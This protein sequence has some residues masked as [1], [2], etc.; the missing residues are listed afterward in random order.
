MTSTSEQEIR[1]AVEVLLRHKLI[2]VSLDCN[3]MTFNVGP[4]PDCGADTNVAC[5]WACSSN[6]PDVNAEDGE[7]ETTA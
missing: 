4:C 5:S 2:E 7:E 6:W 1:D 3:T